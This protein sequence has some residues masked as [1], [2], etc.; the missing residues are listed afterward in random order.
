MD[1]S[2]LA[3]N[4]G[5]T[6]IHTHQRFSWFTKKLGKDLACQECTKKLLK[7]STSSAPTNSYKDPI[8]LAANASTQTLQ[9][10]LA[11]NCTKSSKTRLGA[12]T[13]LSSLSDLIFTCD[14]TAKHFL[15]F[16]LFFSSVL[17]L[18]FSFFLFL[19]SLFLL[20]IFFMCFEQIQNIDKCVPVNELTIQWVNTP[21]LSSGSQSSQV[22]LCNGMWILSH[23]FTTH[24]SKAGGSR[25]HRYAG[26]II[27][28]ARHSRNLGYTCSVALP[29][30]HFFL[31]GCSR[32]LGY[33]DF[34]LPTHL[35]TTLLCNRM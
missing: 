2:N 9:P 20:A 3:C 23:C 34:I 18:F 24:F 15:F 35:P 13:N 17:F 7:D 26:F 33:T 14:L 19:F 16:F 32:T 8:R 31:T 21:L 22:Y 28:M 10:W 6:R 27:F 25:L 12:W 11:E 1:R 30:F 29:F 4:S 5:Q